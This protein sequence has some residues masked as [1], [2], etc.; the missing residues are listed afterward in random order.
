MTRI[1]RRRSKPLAAKS[2]ASTCRAGGT[3]PF[4]LQVVDRIEQ[5]PA[6]QQRPD[7]VDGGPSEIG[8]LRVR[9][10]G[11][12]S[13]PAVAIFRHQLGGEGHARGDRS[14]SRR[15]SCRRRLELALAVVDPGEADVRLAEQRRQSPEIGLFPLGVGVIV[16]LGAIEAQAEKGPGDPAGQANR[17]RADCS[18]RG[19]W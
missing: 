19:C 8:I 7:A 14:S 9:D 6:Q 17:D 1:R 4:G 18:C 12:Q 11:G 2:S 13:L 10:P 16:A 5:R 3:R 15:S